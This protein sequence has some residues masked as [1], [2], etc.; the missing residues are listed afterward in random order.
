MIPLHSVL[1]GIIIGADHGCMLRGALG[2]GCASINV[3]ARQG[4]DRHIMD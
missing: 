4:R 2:V 1:P 3:A